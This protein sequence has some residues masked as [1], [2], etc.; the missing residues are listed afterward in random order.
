MGDSFRPLCPSSRS[1]REV[2]AM[3]G[4]RFPS[5]GIHC[6]CRCTELEEPHSLPKLK[7]SAEKKQKVYL[8]KALD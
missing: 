1:I 3:C 8:L 5:G 7:K 2:Q 6:R 4:W